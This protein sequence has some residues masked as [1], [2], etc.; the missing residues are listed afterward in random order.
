MSVGKA[1]WWKGVALCLFV[2]VV[3]VAAPFPPPAWAPYIDMLIIE[4]R[5][6]WP[7]HPAPTVLASL[8]ETESNW[9]PAARRKTSTEEGAGLGQLTR[10]WR[11]DGAVRFDTLSDLTT[12][13]PTLAPLSWQNVYQRPDLQIKAIVL[14]SK[15]CY[16]RMI[17]DPPSGFENRLAFCTAAY[18]GGEAGVRQERQLCKITT[19]C[20]PNAWFGHVEKTCMK[21][22]AIVPGTKRTFCQVNR[23]HARSVMIDKRAKY[24][25]L[26]VVEEVIEDV[27]LEIVDVDTEQMETTSSP[28]QSWYTR[29][30]QWLFRVEAQ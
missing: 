4:Q 5:Q 9:N 27:V 26:F 3:G 28:P 12:K 29:L 2:P 23:D 25:P 14:M 10:T 24:I 30:W 11:A 6:T 19:E 8:I 15:D 1:L 22:Q 21:S 7:D 16:Q 13:F 17:V 20:N 18:N